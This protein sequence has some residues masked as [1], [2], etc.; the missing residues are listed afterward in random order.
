M[1]NFLDFYFLVPELVIFGSAIILMLVGLYGGDKGKDYVKAGALVA[2][3]A[4]FY[5]LLDIPTREPILLMNGFVQLDGFIVFAKGLVLIAAL[6]AMVLCSHW[7]KLVNEQRFEFPLLMLFSVLGMMLM[8]SSAD[9]LAFYLGLEM[10]SLSLYVMA[11]FARD[12]RGATEAGIKYFIL[13]SL[14]SGLILFGISYLY[15]FSGTTNFVV[16]GNFLSQLPVTGGLPDAQQFALLFGLVF[17]LCGFFFKLS[18]APFHMWAPDVYQGVP[19]PVAA[20]FA[21]A[22]KIAALLFLARFLL[23]PLGDWVMQWQQ[24]LVIVSVASMVIGAFGAVA[25]Q[26]LKRILAFSSIG[27]IGYAMMGIIAASEQGVQAVLIYFALYLFMS[28]GA[29][30]CV[31]LM[32]RDGAEVQRVDDLAGVSR[33]HPYYALL[34][35]VFMFS[36]AGIPPLAGFFGKFYVFLAALEQGYIGLA[37]IGVLSSVVGAYYY[38]RV[39]K[40]MYFDD[41]NESHSLELTRP[42]RVLLLICG[43]VSVFYIFYPAPLIEAAARAAGALWQ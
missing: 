28:T 30:A 41:S 35:A 5:F 19:T 6:L 7:L 37:V 8:L 39:V 18:A 33:S 4:A 3:V 36:L 25:Q 24:I 9:M 22:P 1:L 27:H 16:L 43:G 17:V 34:L 32:K 23:E 11:A 15:G 20:F 13:G 40:V 12:D 38:L 10:M 42:I 2:L 14:A 29:F 26:S 21:T 31:Q